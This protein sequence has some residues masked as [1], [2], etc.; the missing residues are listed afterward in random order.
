MK[1][2]ALEFSSPR[3]SVA[4]LE[5]QTVLAGQSEATGQSVPP[6]RL[7]EQVLAAAKVGRDQIECVAVGLGPGSYNGIRGAIAM[8]QGW[9]LASGVKLLGVSSAQCIAAQAQA[10]EVFGSVRVVIDAQR[11]EFYMTNY[12]IGENSL[13]EA[14]NLRIVTLTEAKSDENRL[15]CVVGPEVTRW[16][17]TGRL[18]FP[19]A[20]MLGQLAATRNDFIYGEQLEPIYL[21]ATTFV[22]A[23]ALRNLPA[24]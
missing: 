3:R 7:V 4:V 21:R 11:G 9:Q 14:V 24:S 10:E 8:A 16:F 6:L 18:I 13:K 2:L 19:G 17:P 1:I 22:K 20:A 5:G 23:P 15:T 12:E